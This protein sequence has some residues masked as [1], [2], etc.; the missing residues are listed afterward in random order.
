MDIELRV[1]IIIN[2]IEDRR[3]L[4]APRRR[5]FALRLIANIIG[6]I[7]LNDLREVVGLISND[8][9]REFNPFAVDTVRTLQRRSMKFSSRYSYTKGDGT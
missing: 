6:W 7:S 5:P 9:I 1:N 4:I 8:T 2:G 3:T